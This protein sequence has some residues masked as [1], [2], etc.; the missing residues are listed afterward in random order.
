MNTAPSNKNIVYSES[1]IHISQCRCCGNKDLQSIISLGE[2]PLA[3]ALL[4]VG[5]LNEPEER[6]PLNVVFC[7][8]CA[9]VQIT[10]TISPE[11]LFGDYLYCSSFSDTV[12]DNAKTIADRLIAA[13]DL[14]K[15]SFIVEIASNDGY[16][17][18][19]YMR[20]GIPV[21]GIEPA[22][23]IAGMAE[24]RGIRT[25]NAFF[26]ESLAM[27]LQAQGDL[28]DVIHANNV[29]AHV[30][31]LHSV[32][33]GISA[34]LKPNG[35]AV[36]EN[37]YVKDLMDN[38]Q[39]DS[40]YHEHLCYYSVTS[41]QRLFIR[42]GLKLINAERIPI[43]GGSLRVF[44]QRIDDSGQLDA[45]GARNVQK[46]LAEEAGWGVS[47]FGFYQS[48]GKRVEQLRGELVALLSKL[49][50][51]GKRIA[52]YGASAKS[53]TLLNYFRIGP[54]ILDYA[55]DRS[56]LKQGL[57]LPGTHLPIHAPA[58]LL[59]T[60]PD[61]V[62]MLAWNFSEEILAQQELYRKNGGKFIIPIPEL[63]I[64]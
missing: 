13:R 8:E 50:S 25:M 6:F 47:N 17:L 26:D 27:H 48:F 62:L 37:H 63:K 15:N 14:D 36:I 32:I 18:Q 45:E 51:A 19:H 28:A 49:K 40:I 10:E 5:Q 56:T 38:V 9:L 53:T 3:N 30:A 46:L 1:P 4:S 21:L 41:F 44:F 64:V 59:Q 31:N 39:F 11:K 2:I 33:S 7:R 23:N 12:L 20:R 16:L 52:V 57:F 24:E 54:E 58:K 42:H 43:H 60:Q 55:V 34:L 61:Y 22:R 29:I 35:I